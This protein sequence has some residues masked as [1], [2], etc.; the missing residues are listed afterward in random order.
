MIEMIAVPIC[1]WQPSTMRILTAFLIPAMLCGQAPTWIRQE[2]SKLQPEVVEWRR[3]FHAHPE[4]S[5]REVRT[6]AKVE[7]ILKGFGMETRRIA[8][9]GVV[10]VLKGALPGPVVGLR[11]DM[12]A[13]PIQEA[14]DVPW[15]STNPGVMH[16]CGHDRPQR[17][18][19]GRSETV[20]RA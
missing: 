4:L 19:F 8:G 18:A 2:A 11:E 6:G 9:H 15:K 10:G 13:L 1:F 7:E 17:D 14:V 20:V 5:N 12:D 16:A 3:D